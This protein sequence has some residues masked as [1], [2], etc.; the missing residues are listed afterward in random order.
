MIDDE[1]GEKYKLELL[2]DESI[3]YLHQR[4]LKLALND[5]EVDN[6]I[7]SSREALKEIRTP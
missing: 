5:V 7:E 6:D 1:D 3:R 4:R 2:K